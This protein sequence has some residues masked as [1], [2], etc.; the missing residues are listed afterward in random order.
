MVFA[1]TKTRRWDTSELGLWTLAPDTTVLQGF[2]LFRHLLPTTSLLLDLPILQLAYTR[3]GISPGQANFIVF[4]RLHGWHSLGFQPP[5][6]RNEGKRT[7]R[8][9]IYIYIYMTH[10]YIYIYTHIE[11]YWFIYCTRTWY[12]MMLWYIRYGTTL[13]Y[14]MISHYAV[15]WHTVIWHEAMYYDVS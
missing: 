14:H 4:W 15:T 5:W 8:I 6:N 11:R 7:K 3:H 12:D 1:T 10:I 9:Y 13:Y 2:D